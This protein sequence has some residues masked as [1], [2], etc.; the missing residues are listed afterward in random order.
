[1]SCRGHIINPPDVRGDVDNGASMK[2]ALPISLWLTLTLCGSAFAQAPAALISSYRLKHGEGRVTM[3]ATLNRIAHAQAAAMASSDVLDHGVLGPFSSRVAAFKH[4]HAG[5]NIA[6]GYDNFPNTLGQWIDSPG[7]REN[8]LMRGAS[9]VGVA[10]ARSAKSGQ[11]YWAM[12]IA[13]G[14]PPA[15]RTKSRHTEKPCRLMLLDEC[16]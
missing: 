2:F 9:K 13:V 11:T 1:V 15:K 6:Y 5:E 12:V 4:E 3:D 7:H 10:S 14:L 8:L 16:L